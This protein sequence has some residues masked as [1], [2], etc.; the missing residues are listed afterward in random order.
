MINNIGYLFA[1]SSNEGSVRFRI[2]HVCEAKYHLAPVF[3]LGFFKVTPCPLS[4]GGFEVFALFLLLLLEKIDWMGASAP[5]YTEATAF[6]GT[7]DF[8]L[9]LSKFHR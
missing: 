6:S 1:N 5:S 8:P 3:P 2:S 7:S 4:P 9:F